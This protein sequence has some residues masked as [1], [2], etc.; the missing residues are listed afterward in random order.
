M[1]VVA[2]WCL[3]TPQLRNCVRYYCE[4]ENEQHSPAAIVNQ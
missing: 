3:R 1:A 4:A 2:D